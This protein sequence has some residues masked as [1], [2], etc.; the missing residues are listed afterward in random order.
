MCEKLKFEERLATIISIGYCSSGIEQIS[1]QIFHINNY[2]QVQIAYQVNRNMIES[3][4]RPVLFHSLNCRGTLVFNCHKTPLNYYSRLNVGS[5]IF[6]L[7]YKHCSKEIFFPMS[8]C[9][10]IIAEIMIYFPSKVF[11]IL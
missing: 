1:N 10:T 4:F 5:F 7:I 9:F 6:L 2:E 3:T 11:S 8:H